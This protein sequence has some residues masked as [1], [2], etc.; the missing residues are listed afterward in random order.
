MCTYVI[1]TNFLNFYQYCVRKKNEKQSKNIP[2]IVRTTLRHPLETSLSSYIRGYSLFLNISAYNYLFTWNVYL[3]CSS[4]CLVSGIV[5]GVFVRLFAIEIRQLKVGAFHGLKFCKLN[6]FVQMT[7]FLN[8]Y[9]I[10]V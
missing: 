9:G 6:L 10:K 4:E 3:I 7:S 1:F 8:A 2:R 5:N